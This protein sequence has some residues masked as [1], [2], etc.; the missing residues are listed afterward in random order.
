MTVEEEWITKKKT[1]ELT[2]A[3]RFFSCCDLCSGVIKWKIVAIVEI[4]D[5]IAKKRATRTLKKRKWKN[6][7]TL[8]VFERFEWSQPRNFAISSFFVSRRRFCFVFDRKEKPWR[9]PC[10]VFSTVY[11]VFQARTARIV[12]LCTA[13]A[14]LFRPMEFDCSR[15]HSQKR[16]KKIT[17]GFHNGTRQPAAENDRTHWHKS[18]LHS[19]WR[20]QSKAQA[21]KKSNWY[22]SG[23]FC[24][25]S[26]MTSHSR[27]EFTIANQKCTIIVIYTLHQIGHRAAGGSDARSFFHAT[28][29]SDWSMW[30]DRCKMP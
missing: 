15:K 12:I 19:S 28:P 5:E 23:V 22:S 11:F 27:F 25:D 16:R 17:F 29:L 24:G 3:F 13:Q 10:R 20:G 9:R 21:K 7:T 26:I 14:N 30:V 4:V 6:R 1:D 18:H 2:K 8:I